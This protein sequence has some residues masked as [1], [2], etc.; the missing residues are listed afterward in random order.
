MRLRRE[1]QTVAVPVFQFGIFG[2]KSLGFHAGP[3]FDF[4]G[5]VHTNQSLHLASGNGSH[6]DL[7]R[8][9]H[10]VHP[11]GAQHADATASRS[12]PPT[13]RAPCRF[14]R[15]S[16][17]RPATYRNLATTESSGTT[18]APW[19][20]WKNLSEVTYRTNI[21]TEATG[22]KQ[23][24][25]PLTSQGA[26][27]IDLIKRPAVESNENTTNA[28]VFGQRYFAQAS[29]RILLSDRAADLTNLPTITRVR[30]LIWR[31]WRPG[32]VVAP[33]GQPAVTASVAPGPIATIGG[34]PG[35]STT[36]VSAIMP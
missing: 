30:R 33:V 21:R 8:Q 36:R 11:G 32:Y 9:D 26:T 3:N 6:A 14:R 31:I 5:R 13:T 22:A 10:R 19:G 35:T 15:S 12:R 2:E 23:L 16:A 20:G 24:N 7:P 27:P 29:L 17:A 28:A 25:L 34:V 18:A 1:L 4:G